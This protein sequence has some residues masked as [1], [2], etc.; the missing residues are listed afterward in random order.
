MVSG[1]LTRATVVEF[2]LKH[3]DTCCS[4]LLY[5][6]ILTNFSLLCFHIHFYIVCSVSIK[7]DLGVLNEIEL[8]L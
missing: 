1:F 4:I 3:G 5:R 8:H 6:I 2:G 7:N